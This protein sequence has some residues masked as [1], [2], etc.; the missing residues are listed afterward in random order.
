MRDTARVGLRWIVSPAVDDVPRGQ[1]L[2]GT[3]LGARPWSYGSM[4]GAH[5]VILASSA[6]RMLSVDGPRAGLSRG[7]A[8]VQVWGGLW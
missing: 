4:I 6:G 3:A 7:S 5:V 2:S 1:A 8:L